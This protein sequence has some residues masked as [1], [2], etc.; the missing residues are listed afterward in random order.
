MMFKEALKNKAFLITGASSGI[1][2]A[3]AIF[4]ANLGATV[5]ITAR[6]KN[7]LDDTFSALAG[8]GHH[9]F[10]ADIT[11]EQAVNSLMDDIFYRAGKL[12]G[13]AH[14]AGVQHTMPLQMT[15][16]HSF[17][18]LFAVN[19]KSALFLAKSFRKKGRYNPNGSSIVFLSSAAA[20]SGES[21]ISEYSASK[22]ALQGLARSLA[23]ELAKQKIRVN[24][25]APG[26]VDTK[27][28]AGF[29]ATLTPKQ[30]EIIVKK[31]PLGIGQTDDIIMPIAFL[32]S[33]DARWITGINLPV[34]GGYLLG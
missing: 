7:R 19:V 32:L 25:V 9:Q 11:N 5:V 28:S 23:A 13:L 21:G 22:F 17:E 3:T 4:L 30:F 16:E 15:S 20:L 6:D 18:A 14:C 29:V 26:V 34:D 8:N 2:R 27:M 31:H 24:C 12:D 10:I 1:G 33:D